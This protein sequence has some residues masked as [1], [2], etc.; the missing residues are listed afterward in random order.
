MKK[1]L[2]ILFIAFSLLVTTGAEAAVLSVDSKAD[3]FGLQQEFVIPIMLNTENEKINALAGEINFPDHLLEVKQIS[4]GDSLINFWV[5]TPAVKSEG[6]I[7]FSG[8]VPG[9]YQGSVRPVFLI[10]FLTKKAGTGSIG[11][12]K[13]EALKNDGQGTLLPVIAQ[14]FQFKV[15][16]QVVGDILETAIDQ[17]SP[18]VFK[19][20]ISSSEYLFDGQNVLFFSAQDKQSGIDRYEVKEVRHRI[21]GWLADW[22]A[23][24][25]PYLLVD[26]KL[27]SYVYV[28]AIDRQNNSRIA[29]LSPPNSPIWYENSDIWIIIILLALGVWGYKKYVRKK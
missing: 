1:Y 16:D 27:N 28:K 15:S 2:S 3:S 26:Q 8:I 7:V 23:A 24:E 14:P 25:S 4:D 19:P 18:E 21:V 17:V 20:E 5:E 10:T 11:F 12:S 9:G 29:K 6:K 22:V 13:L